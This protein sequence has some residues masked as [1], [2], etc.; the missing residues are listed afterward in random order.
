MAHQIKQNQSGAVTMV[1]ATVLLFLLSMI[2]VFSARVMITDH[3]ISSNNYLSAQSRSAAQAAVEEA[4][5]MLIRA[6]VIGT[7]ANTDIFPN[8]PDGQCPDIDAADTGR[9]CIKN[10]A[11]IGIGIARARY[12]ASDDFPNSVAHLTIDAWSPDGTAQKT[13]Q[14]RVRFAEIV[15][16]DPAAPLIVQGNVNAPNVTLNNT[17]VAP[18]P[19]P[20][21]AMWIGGSD[22]A[23]T[24]SSNVNSGANLGLY[25]GQGAL[26]GLNTADLMFDNFFG[27]DK[28]SVQNI[29]TPIDCTG[30]CNGNAAQIAAMVGQGGIFW[31]TGNLNLH[32]NTDL[33]TSN[34][35]IILIVE[36]G[37]QLS[38]GNASSEIFGLVFQFGNWTANNSKGTIHGSLIVQGNFTENGS[39]IIDYG[40]AAGM[41]E[42]DALENLGI[43]SPIA[44]SWIDL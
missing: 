37:A 6:N 26:N 17:T 22:A 27:F 38:L 40:D 28:V 31:L 5:N 8:T 16:N 14:Q 10:D 13:S 32:N 7:V 34:N 39:L 12:I 23:G 21:V 24:P 3:K 20:D 25:E 4:M 1:M 2:S 15:P 36:N 11:G 18:N 44:G 33:G 9:F 43:Y 29:A 19:Y 41:P 35:P 42:L 30:G